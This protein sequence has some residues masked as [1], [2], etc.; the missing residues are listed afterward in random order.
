MQDTFT[1]TELA[2]IFS[3]AARGPEVPAVETIARSLGLVPSDSAD[4]AGALVSLGARGL[5]TEGLLAGGAL[6][7][8]QAALSTTMVRGIA[9]FEEREN[10]ETT[11]RTTVLTGPRGH[12][13]LWECPDGRFKL[14]TAGAQ[15]TDPGVNLAAKLA[16]LA[17]EA[18]V[19]G[20]FYRLGTDPWTG[21]RLD[22][23]TSFQFAEHDGLGWAW[24]P[25]NGDAEY[26]FAE[27]RF[28]DIL[29]A[30]ASMD[31]A[32]YPSPALAGAH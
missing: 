25:D 2:W 11:H 18:I 30:I 3:T 26:P 6:I 32:A 27:A 5:V 24:R 22:A 9:T 12:V 14:S 29:A 31:P 17:E 20:T 4:P 8:H 28:E 15:V 1:R 23:D 13:S 16:N 10:A 21:N 19:E 7:L